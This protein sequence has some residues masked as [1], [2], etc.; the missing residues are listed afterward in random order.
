MSVEKLKLKKNHTWKSK[1]GYSI[2]V[3]D[4]GAA[5][6]DHPSNWKF[7]MSDDAVFCTTEPSIESCDLGVSLFRVPVGVIAELPM[8]EMLFQSL[9]SERE[10][11]HQS[12]IHRIDR[13]DMDV[14]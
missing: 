13:G 12:E 10:T 8:E 7:E 4:R 2:C 1:P 11:Y 9:Y 5:R 14:V 6:F 3:L